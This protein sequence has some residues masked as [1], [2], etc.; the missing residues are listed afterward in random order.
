VAGPVVRI[1]GAAELSRAFRAAGGSVR[2]LSGAYRE[3]ART[4]LPPA[5][6]DAPRGPTGRLAGSTRGLGQRTRAIL[7]AGSARVPYAG[8]IH[9][10]NPSTKTYPAHKSGAKRSTGTLGVIRANPWLYRTADHRRAEVVDAFDKNV[11]A[12]L[13]AQGLTGPLP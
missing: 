5:Q 4:L 6:R 11:G 8:P 2:D 3:V 10:G 13:R 12:V 7:A 1:E 9:F